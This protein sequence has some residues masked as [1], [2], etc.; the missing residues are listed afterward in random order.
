MRV[1]TL[2]Q[3]LRLYRRVEATS[4]TQGEYHGCLVKFPASVEGI[5]HGEWESRNTQN[6]TSG[7]RTEGVEMWNEA[8]CDPFKDSYVW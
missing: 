1:P 4:A 5:S 8:S 2:D 6:S 7:K 3:T